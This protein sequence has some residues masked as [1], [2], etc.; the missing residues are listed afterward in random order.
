V[1]Y[2]W[3]EYIQAND[4]STDNRVNHDSTCEL[5]E[6]QEPLFVPITLRLSPSRAAFPS[7]MI[8]QARKIIHSCGGKHTD[9]RGRKQV[10]DWFFY[11]IQVI[12]VAS[13]WTR[14]RSC[15]YRIR[16]TAP[17]HPLGTQQWLVSSSRYLPTETCIYQLMSG[18]LSVIRE[19][20]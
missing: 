16:S 2:T 15:I 12:S 20:F 13:G 1:L 3:K 7:S 10:Y 11:S 19:P 6:Q 14:L 5:A 4:E 9:W 18:C 8:L 17:S